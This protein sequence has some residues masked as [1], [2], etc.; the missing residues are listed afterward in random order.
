M[1]PW[2]TAGI[3]LNPAISIWSG[4]LLKCLYRPH[5]TNSTYMYAMRIDRICVWC[6]DWNRIL[7]LFYLNNFL[8]QACS[9]SFV[10][11]CPYR[12]Y[13]HYTNTISRL[14]ILFLFT[15]TFCK[16]ENTRKCWRLKVQLFVKLLI[17]IRLSFMNKVKIKRSCKKDITLL[18]L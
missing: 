1:T 13:V 11:N 8:Q 6:R 4:I 16:F 18:G 12:F 3:L 15:V 5:N 9:C 10:F 2:S 17:N 7:L 14:W